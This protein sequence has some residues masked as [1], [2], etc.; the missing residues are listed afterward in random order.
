MEL[1]GSSWE[2][3]RRSIESTFNLNELKILA[4]DLNIEY[5]ELEGSTRSAKTG[6]L[7]EY[8]CRHGVIDK[9]QDKLTRDRPETNWNAINWDQVCPDVAPAGLDET[10]PYQGL[11]Y[12][13]VGDTDRYF[14]RDALIISLIQRINDE[15]LNFL[16]IVG[17]SGS[18]KSSLVRAGLI[19]TLQGNRPQLADT[20]LPQDSKEWPMA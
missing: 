7:I 10:P 18:G 16:M 9:L 15:N 8:A 11:N 14:G 3:L 4:L 5:E 20:K 13:D 12:F 2:Q 1:Q 17:A 19:P 6:S